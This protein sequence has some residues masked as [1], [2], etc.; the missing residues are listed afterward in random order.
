MERS[1]SRIELGDQLPLRMPASRRIRSAV[2]SASLTLVGVLALGW[3]WLCLDSLHERQRAEHLIADLK[4]FPF[5][6]AGFVEVREL[7]KRYGGTAVQSFPLLQFLPPGPP[8]VK[9]PGSTDPQER[10]PLVR[11]RPTCTPQD[12]I[13]DIRIRP[14]RFSLPL[15]YETSWFLYSG[16]ARVGLRPWIVS[17]TYEVRD[18]K[19]WE[20]RTGVGQF[21][22]TR[23]GLY[24][25][26]ILLGY[27]VISM[28]RANALDSHHRQEYAVGVPH[29]TGTVSDDLNT[30]FVQDS[31]APLN[32]AF[33]VR[34]QCLTAIANHACP[35]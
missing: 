7:A 9:F 21:R 4:S 33:D 15:N 27:Q 34:L 24:E 25:G 23:P 19:L 3:L 17:G 20:T 11:T 16:L 31:N 10:M 29:V 1:L 30:W 12:C 28:S 14:R 35:N 13:F 32:R 5:A 2:L 8:L 18:G 22:H 6:T 26:L